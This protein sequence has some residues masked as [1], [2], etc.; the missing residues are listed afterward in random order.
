[1]KTY[2]QKPTEVTR[3]WF[4]VDATGIPLG[5]LTVEVAKKLTGK[6]KPTYTPHIDGG[7][8]VVV[9]N[10]KQV[11]ATGDK[12]RSK[13][14]YRH[15]GYPGS[16]KATTLEQQLEKDPTEVIKKAVYGMIP[17]NKLREER[18]KRLKVYT[19][20]EHAHDPQK[21][22]ELSLKKGEK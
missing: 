9:I 4:I 17:K 10:A 5:R 6:Q 20:A 15:S 2:S 12:R 11:K 13:V 16:T 7:D 8:Y 19:E 22:K 18:M 1:M 21:P 14:Y 3:E